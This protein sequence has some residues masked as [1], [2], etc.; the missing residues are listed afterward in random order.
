MGPQVLRHV[1]S[2]EG[3]LFSQLCEGSWRAGASVQS[4]GRHA[5]WRSLQCR[6]DAGLQTVPGFRDL[7]LEPHPHPS[8]QA[9]GG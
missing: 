6:V 2:E 3:P 8:L 1:G 5:R 9:H 4:S 7:K